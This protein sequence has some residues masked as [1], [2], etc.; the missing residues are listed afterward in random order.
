MAG[1]QSVTIATCRGACSKG[2][3]TVKES[4]ELSIKRLADNGDAI[5][6]EERKK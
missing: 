5:T 6:E 2:E 4:E 1:L 3:E